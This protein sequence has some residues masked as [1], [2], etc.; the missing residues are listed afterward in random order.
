MYSASQGVVTDIQ[1]DAVVHLLADSPILPTPSEAQGMLCGFACGGETDPVTA[2]LGQLLPREDGE[3][4]AVGAARDALLPL[5]D[6]TCRQLRDADCGLQLLLPD[7][8][9]PLAARAIGL[10]DWVRG[11]LYAFGIQ[12]ISDRDLSGQAREI[13]RDLAD[14]TRMDCDDLPDD[15]ENEQALAE[16][17]EFVRVAAM[18]LYAELGAADEAPAP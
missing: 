4:L 7:E 10:Y 9:A 6:A 2:W 18:L 11:F 15:E 14:L 12:G 3:D 17:T 8:D 5:G 16:L 13:L 1:H